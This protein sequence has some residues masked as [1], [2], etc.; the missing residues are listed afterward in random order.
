MSTIKKRFKANKRIKKNMLFLLIFIMFLV[1]SFLSIFKTLYSKIT[2]DKNDLIKYLLSNG[3]NNSIDNFKL[4][5]I[6]NLNS[7]DFL[8]QYSLGISLPKDKTVILDED[9]LEDLKVTGDYI[10]DPVSNESSDPVIY[11]YNTHQTEAYAL[12]YLE[13]YS[14]K[15]TVLLASYMLREKLNDLNIPTIVETSNVTD[16][17]NAY[18]WKYGYSYKVSRMMLEEAK[19][20]NPTLKY[21][22]DLHRDAGTHAKTTTTINNETY[23]KVLFVVGLDHDNYTPNLNLA[24]ELNTIFNK[25]YPSL[26]RGVIT[27]SGKGV[28]GIYNQDFDQ[29]TILIEIGG[30]YN[31]VDEVNNTISAF[32]DI[33]FKYIKGET[34]EKEE[35]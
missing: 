5:D 20:N 31:T 18:G 12:G 13:P 30:Q 17:L 21:F 10:V 4:S 7:T 23:A 8:L 33:L 35:T 16:M 32:S 25:Y 24:N 2:I 9:E 26:S 22:I 3:T 29:N 14:I 28:N 1:L 6:L 11:I 19:K 15:P 34:N 27:K